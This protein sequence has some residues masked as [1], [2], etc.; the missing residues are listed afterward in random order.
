M[1]AVYRANRLEKKVFCH[2]FCN[3][4]NWRFKI[5]NDK[6]NQHTDMKN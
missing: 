4:F 1:H 2:I 3:F 6:N 5:D